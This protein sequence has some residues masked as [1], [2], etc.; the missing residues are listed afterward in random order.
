MIAPAD[1]YMADVEGFRRTTKLAIERA[2][3]HD[4]LVT[5]G[6]KPSRPETGY[7]YLK[8][9]AAMGSDGCRKIEAF[10]EKPDLEKAKKFVADGNYLWNGGMFVWRAEVILAAFDRFMPEMKRAWDSAGGDIE[11]AYPKPQADGD[12]DRFRRDGKGAE[13]RDLRARLRLG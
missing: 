11:R 6:V 7:G 1:H 12:F 4:E 3:T 9:A 10:V 5:M 13:R 2:K 8:T